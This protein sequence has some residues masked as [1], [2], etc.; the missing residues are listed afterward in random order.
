MNANY[1]GTIHREIVAIRLLLEYKI[2]RKYNH[3]I[4][5]RSYYMNSDG[6]KNLTDL[7]AEARAIHYAMQHGEITY[8]EAKSKT[9]S[10]INEVNK[11]IKVIA[12]K[13][14]RKPKYIRFQDLGNHL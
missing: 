10:I 8:E 13:Y 7:L 1:A 11:T 6:S 9:Q 3:L 2:H 5:Y 14:N 12:K 4:N